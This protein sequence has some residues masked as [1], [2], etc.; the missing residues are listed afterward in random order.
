MLGPVRPIVTPGPEPDGLGHDDLGRLAE[1]LRADGL[2]V[3]F[4]YDTMIVDA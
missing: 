4:A 2:P 3:E 1:R